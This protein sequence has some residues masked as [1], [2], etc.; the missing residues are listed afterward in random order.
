MKRL[1]SWILVAGAAVRLTRFIT[2]DTLGEWTIR[3]PAKRWG[4]KADIEYIKQAEASRKTEEL[5][6]RLENEE[7][8]TPQSKLAS[9]LEC[10]FCV[11]FWISLIILLIDRVLPSR[12]ILRTLWRVI[13]GALT[14]N[15]VT[16]HISARLD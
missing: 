3:N 4:E 15:Y 11:G 12:G 9:G 13:S 7:P 1:A 6:A 10:P 8:L 5:A 14:L 2:T 16:A